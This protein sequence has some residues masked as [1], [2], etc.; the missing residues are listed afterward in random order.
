L[1]ARGDIT[2]AA[3]LPAS[4]AARSPLAADR[5]VTAIRIEGVPPSI[6][7]S[8]AA[9]RVE[10]KAARDMG[11]LDQAE[12]VALWRWIRDIQAFA[13]ADDARQVWRIS[14]TPLAG[15]FVV[16]TVSRQIAAEAVYD[17]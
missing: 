16:E 5:A 11:Q 12:S 3:H 2:A 17:W 13:G 1:S 4:I 15:P 10:V 6:E 14:V 8:G 9:V 7:P